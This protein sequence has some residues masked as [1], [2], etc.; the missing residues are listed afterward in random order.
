MLLLTDFDLA[1][2]D[3][4]KYGTISRFGSPINPKYRT[5]EFFQWTEK[6]RRPNLYI[7]EYL[8]TIEAKIIGYSKERFLLKIIKKDEKYLRTRFF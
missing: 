1:I 7:V 4:K 8:I 3:V 6:G 2:A 5:F